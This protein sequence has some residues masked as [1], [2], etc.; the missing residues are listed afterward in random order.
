MTSCPKTFALLDIALIEAA[1]LSGNLP[2]V[3]KQLS[4]WYEFR[5]R[6]RNKLISGLM[7]PIFIL[8]I[9]IFV[10]ALPPLFLGAIDFTEYLYRTLRTLLIIYL[11]VILIV[12]LIKK[13]PQDG[14]IRRFIDAFSLRIPIL[15][16]GVWHLSL[17]QYCRTF[18]VL[19]KAGVPITQCAEKAT[20]LTS[21]N[22]CRLL[23]KMV[24]RIWPMDA[25]HCIFFHLPFYNLPDLQKPWDDLFHQID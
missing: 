1:D 11:P 19:Y 14:Y 5:R 9:A 10:G 4:Q 15:G 17:S 3:L 25:S 12:V 24:R 13:T 6:L 2:Q 18:Y 22:T 20:D 7:L 21:K 16:S 8:N 23:R